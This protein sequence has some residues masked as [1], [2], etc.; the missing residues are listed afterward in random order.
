MGIRP[1]YKRGHISDNIERGVKRKSKNPSLVCLICGT[2][3]RYYS[4]VIFVPVVA[5]R[6]TLAAQDAKIESLNKKLKASHT[7]LQKLTRLLE[8]QRQAACNAGDE[9]NGVD[10][11]KAVKAQGNAHSAFAKAVERSVDA[12]GTGSGRV[13]IL[14]PATVK[15]RNSS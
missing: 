6:R 3:I 8:M 15:P 1:L 9:K 11:G 13:M 12:V 5:H 2:N 10:L 4:S 14:L 7:T